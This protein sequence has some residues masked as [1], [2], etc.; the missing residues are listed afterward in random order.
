M[1]TNDT[2]GDGATESTITFHSKPDQSI[3][4]I[5]LADKDNV[6]VALRDLASGETVEDITLV[7]DVA[8]GHKLSVSKITKGELV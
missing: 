3:G 2:G 4:C 7:D 1:S 8:R 6:V 5:R